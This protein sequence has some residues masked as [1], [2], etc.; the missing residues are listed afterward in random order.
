MPQIEVEFA[1]KKYGPFASVQDA[2]AQG[3][4]IPDLCPCKNCKKLRGEKG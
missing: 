4:H 3:F 1:G 2:L